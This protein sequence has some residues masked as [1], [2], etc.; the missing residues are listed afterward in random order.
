MLDPELALL[1]AGWA[2]LANFVLVGL[3]ALLATAGLLSLL[4]LV[5]GL[6]LLFRLLLILIRLI[7]VLV[8]HGILLDLVGSV[9]E[10]ILLR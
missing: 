6:P 10:S 4:L 1:A 8:A 5:L 7:T 2:T 9:R 3:G